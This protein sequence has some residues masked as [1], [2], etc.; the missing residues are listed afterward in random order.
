MEKSPIGGEVWVGAL[1]ADEFRH[2][3]TCVSTATTRQAQL[4]NKAT[5]PLLA[6]MAIFAMPAFAETD[7]A[8]ELKQVHEQR[9]KAIAAAVEPINQ[10][11]KVTLEQMLRRV[12]QA[13]DLDTAVAIKEELSH[14]SGGTTTDVHT[15]LA[16]ALTNGAWTWFG[17]GMRTSMVF[18]SD[19]SVT[20]KDWGFAAKWS[21][22]GLRTVAI[23]PSKDGRVPAILKFDNTITSFTARDFNGKDKVSGEHQ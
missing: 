22:T 7:L 11:Y 12:T 23:V 19:G 14:L 15:E 5:I 13:T 10:K 20:N 6:G 3:C 2:H 21:I 9:E 17:G 8:R 18:N 16:H 4:M 1:K